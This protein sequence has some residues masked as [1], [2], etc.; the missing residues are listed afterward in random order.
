MLL[1][2]G[3][4]VAADLLLGRGHECGVDDLT[5]A[6]DIATAQQLSRYPVEQ[7]LGAGFS[8]P[9]LE[10]PNRSAIQDVSRLTQA[11]LYI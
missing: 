7:R 3:F 1:K 2:D 8:D 9:V 5:A 11:A 6:R 10:G 4:L